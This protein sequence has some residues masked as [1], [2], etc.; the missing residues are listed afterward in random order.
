MITL[1]KIASLFTTIIAIFYAFRDAFDGNKQSAI[2]NLLLSFLNYTAYC[3][4]YYSEK[5]K[6]KM[7]CENEKSIYVKCDYCYDW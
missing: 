6:I 2:H 7:V 3:I 5:E 4:L 1:L